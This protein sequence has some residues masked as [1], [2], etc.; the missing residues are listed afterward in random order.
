MIGQGC[1]VALCGAACLQEQIARHEALPAALAA[2]TVAQRPEGIAVAELNLLSHI[3]Y[4]SPLGFFWQPLRKPVQ[5]RLFA[6]L[7]DVSN[8]ALSYADV[9]RLHRP[10]IAASKVAWRFDRLRYVPR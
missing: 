10:T 2:Y 7:E 8:P 9:A 5:H 1:S 3:R 6:I 4:S